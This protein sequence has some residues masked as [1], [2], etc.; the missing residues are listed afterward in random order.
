[1]QCLQC[2]T[3]AEMAPSQLYARCPAC[4]SLFMNVAGNWQLYP[5]E[6]SQ[7]NMIEHSLGFSNP[8]EADTH[9]A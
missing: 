3:E 5:V 4:K 1:M 6:D 2:Q 8:A 7:R 9:A